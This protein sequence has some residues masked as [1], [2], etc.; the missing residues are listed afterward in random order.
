MNDEH[1]SLLCVKFC[2]IICET[3]IWYTE[4]YVLDS[5]SGTIV[6]GVDHRHR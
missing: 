6:T 4:L 5:V 1:F 3:L 2:K